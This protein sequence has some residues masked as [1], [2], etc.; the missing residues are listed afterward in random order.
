MDSR[1]DPIR[2]AQHRYPLKGRPPKRRRRRRRWFEPNKPHVYI[3]CDRDRESRTPRIVLHVVGPVPG[4]GATLVWFPRSRNFESTC[5]GRARSPDDDGYDFVLRRE[6]RPSG[7]KTRGACT[8]AGLK[9]IPNE[10][11]QSLLLFERDTGVVSYG[12]PEATRK[13]LCSSSAAPM[14]RIPTVGSKT[15][16]QMTGSPTI[17]NI[18]LFRVERRL[19]RAIGS[20]RALNIFAEKYRRPSLIL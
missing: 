12:A 3:V 20:E 10:Q 16:R 4:G 7:R 8:P 14:R 2:R 19:S 6:P 9:E 15:P 18:Y 5:P 17:I 1:S 13:L 11:R